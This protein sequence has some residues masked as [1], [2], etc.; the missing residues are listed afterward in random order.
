MWL[1][2]V[3]CVCV[4][5]PCG[6]I[7]DN[8]NNRLRRPKLT[9]VSFISMGWLYSKRDL[10]TWNWGRRGRFAKASAAGCRGRPAAPA[11]RPRAPSSRPSSGSSRDAISRDPSRSSVTWPDLAAGA[12]LGNLQQQPT[13]ATYIS[14]AKHDV[15]S[16]DFAVTRFL[17][18]LFR[19][20]NINVIDECRLF[21]N[22]M[23]LS[24]KIEKRISFESKVLNCNSLLYYI[25]ICPKLC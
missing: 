13:T 2:A 14:V 3:V 18:K 20:T 11:R 24:K 8:N 7:N 9:P 10:R 21:F 12:P 6:V 4:G 19:S 15:K 1:C 23:L 22:V 25:N 5:C 16:L 17:M